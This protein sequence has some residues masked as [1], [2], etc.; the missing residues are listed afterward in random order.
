MAM[1]DAKTSSCLR[2]VL[3]ACSQTI[4][5]AMDERQCSKWFVSQVAFVAQGAVSLGFAGFRWVSLGFAGHFPALSPPPLLA[6][7][8]KN[9][10]GALARFRLTTSVD[11]CPRR[12]NPFAQVSGPYL[13]WFGSLKHQLLGGLKGEAP[14]FFLWVAFA[15][16]SIGKPKGKPPLL[17][18]RTPNN[19]FSP[20][21]FS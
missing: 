19:L 3:Q 1:V 15:C 7:H 6:H 16:R 11:P 14:L 10:L 9:Q 2:T 20:V 21:V 12:K 4:C 5:M 18:P 8:L 17:H 13:S